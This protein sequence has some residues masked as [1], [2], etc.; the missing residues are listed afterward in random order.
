MSDEARPCPYCGAPL[1]AGFEVDQ[2][3]E[4]RSSEP[5]AVKDAEPEVPAVPLIAPGSQDDD[6]LGP[7]GLHQDPDSIQP[8][9]ILGAFVTPASRSGTSLSTVINLDAR[10]SKTHRADEFEDDEPEARRASWPLV[11]LASYASAMTLAFGWAW[12]KSRPRPEVA[13]EASPAPPAPARIDSARQQGLSK[14]VEPPEPILGENFAAIGKTLRVGSLEITPEDVKREGVTLQR[15]NPFARPDPKDGG[16]RAL[17]LRLRLRNV[18]DDAAF[19]PLDQLYL[20]ER[21]DR[22]VDT[23]VETGRNERIYPY[24]LAVDSEW[25]VVGQDFTELRPRESRVVAIVTAPEAPGDEAGPFNWRVRL[26]TGI[27]RTDVIGLRW[28]PKPS[29]PADTPKS[30]TDAPKAKPTDAPKSKTDA[31]KSK[32]DAPKSKTDKG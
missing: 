2:F 19:S 17:V 9:P 12:I 24:P 5:A 30:K 4:G 28:E 22:V 15:S 16:K 3:G 18:T 25:S 29:K 26:R 13:V 8:D 27:G 7:S 1:P 11:I 23:F 20:R 14:Q 6:F 21:G 10:P 31:P 32:T